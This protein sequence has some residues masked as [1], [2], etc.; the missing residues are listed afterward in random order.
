MEI[1]T[2]DRL[3]ERSTTLQAA[4]AELAPISEIVA[5]EA[6][7]G[8]IPQPAWNRIQWSVA[9]A[10]ATIHGLA[11]LLAARSRWVGPPGWRGFLEEQRAAI[12]ARM[13][14]ITSLTEEIGRAAAVAGVPF[15]ALKGAALAKLGLLT[16]GTRP[17]SDVDLLIPRD[18]S[19]RMQEVL[20][21]LGYAPGESTWKH[22][23]FHPKVSTS[24]DGFGEH[25]DRAINID[26]HFQV[27]ERLAGTEV[28][29]T[30][31][32]GVESWQPGLNPYPSSVHL[33]RHLLLHSAGC[34]STHW[35]R[36]IQ[37]EDLSLLG[38][39]LTSEDWHQLAVRTDDGSPW[40][41]WPVLDV[42]RRYSRLAPPPEIMK[43]FER[44][45]PRLLRLVARRASLSE[46]SASNIRIV[47]FPA[48]AWSGSPLGLFRYVRSRFWPERRELDSYRKL[49]AQS[50]FAR[51]QTWFGLSHG[52]RIA[53]WLV[54]RPLRHAAVHAV[55]S[56]LSRF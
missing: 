43:L 39:Q 11:G 23:Q 54:D 47:P 14:R 38:T 9:A 21:T 18:H 13:A 16:P 5:L 45:C 37:L 40:W 42:A 53:R 49:G 6:L 1:P 27:R 48:L 31:S 46:V 17:T 26:L 25:P 15:L 8:P 30:T 7:R 20:G 44:Q 35:L 24:H 3:E 10:A 2:P 12:G 50:E 19:E 33:M 28:D 55:R 22:L 29:L 41:I 32:L 34:A 51:A 52:R 4:L 36:G 56:A